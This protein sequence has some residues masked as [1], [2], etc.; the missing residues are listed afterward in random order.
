MKKKKDKRK[1]AQSKSSSEYM[2]VEKC[3]KQRREK[4]MLDKARL[5]K[6]FVARKLFN[7]EINSIDVKADLYYEHELHVYNNSLTNYSSQKAF[8]STE[9]I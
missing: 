5:L 6:L 4:G 7:C 8:S 1:K 9:Y 3:Y 2:L